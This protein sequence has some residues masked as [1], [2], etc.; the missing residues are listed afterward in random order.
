MAG[1]LREDSLLSGYVFFGEEEY[2][3][4]EFIEEL[5]RVLTASAGGSST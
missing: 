1:D 4:E 3:A 5:E 2:L